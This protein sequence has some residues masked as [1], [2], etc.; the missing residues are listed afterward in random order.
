MSR[1]VHLADTYDAMTSRRTYRRKSVHPHR[2][3]TWMLQDPEQQF[4]ALL[5]KY[6]VHTLGLFPP[7]STVR[8]DSGCVGVVVRA[9][10][11]PQLLGR[12]QVCILLEADGTAAEPGAFVDL[13]ET[14]LVSEG[15]RGTIEAAVDPDPLGISPAAVILAE[16]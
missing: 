3:I 13:S 10:R 9:N 4:D 16:I 11:L 8:L 2:V 14:L 12:P 1:I 6:L 15:E 7:G 5:V